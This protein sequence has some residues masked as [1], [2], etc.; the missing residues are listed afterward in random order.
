MVGHAEFHL[1]DNSQVVSVGEILLREVEEHIRMAENPQVFF[2][3]N[4]NT[5]LLVLT[6]IKQERI[7]VNL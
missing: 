7:K 6:W 4:E 5:K 3:C 2:Q 1:L